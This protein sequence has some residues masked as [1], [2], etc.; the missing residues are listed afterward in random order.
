MLEREIARVDQE[1][2]RLSD[3]EG[4]LPPLPEARPLHENGGLADGNAGDA[5]ER[6]T[7]AMLV[8]IRGLLCEVLANQRNTEPTL[9]VYEGRLRSLR[10]SSCAT[11]PDVS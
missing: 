9:R 6:N 2:S 8:R 10:T 1:L 5:P 4:G 7:I 11:T 3:L